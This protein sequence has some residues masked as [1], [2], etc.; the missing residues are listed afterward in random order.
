[1]NAARFRPRIWLPLLSALC[2]TLL[3]GVS[4]SRA[5]ESRA[6]TVQTR[7]AAARVYL[8]V[9]PASEVFS[10]MAARMSD[11]MEPAQA[12]AFKESMRSSLDI[13]LIERSMTEALVKHFTVKEI[14]ALTVFHRSAEGRSIMKK[15]PAYTA[16]MMPVIREQLFQAGLRGSSPAAQ[17]NE[18]KTPAGK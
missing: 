7:T 12:A 6:D 10:A 2:T 14:R 16:E 9:V 1:M 4:F 18:N 17:S 11:Q 15:M 5:D 8:K 3:F 13:P